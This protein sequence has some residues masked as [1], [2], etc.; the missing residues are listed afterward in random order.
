MDARAKMLDRIVSRAGT[1]EDLVVPERSRLDPPINYSSNE[2]IYG[3]KIN[4]TPEVV[5]TKEN[6]EH[7]LILSY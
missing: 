3:Y 2:L 4:K 6:G 1:R 7:C 5:E